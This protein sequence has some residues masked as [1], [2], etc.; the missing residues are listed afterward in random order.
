[1][2]FALDM[3]G[4]D[5]EASAGGFGKPPTLTVGHPLGVPTAVEH[6][7]GNDIAVEQVWKK[8]SRGRQGIARELATA[9][10]EGAVQGGTAYT[11]GKGALN[12]D[13]AA[14]AVAYKLWFLLWEGGE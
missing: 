2:A 1:M 8:L 12:A 10:L 13:D 5:T 6:P 14:K 4:F 7:P 11:L 3:L 9:A